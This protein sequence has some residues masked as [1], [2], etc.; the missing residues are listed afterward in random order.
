MEHVTS[1]CGVGHMIKIIE[2]TSDTIIIRDCP[3]RIL[4]MGLCILAIAAVVFTGLADSYV[5]N[6]GRVNEYSTILVLLFSLTGLAIGSCII[7]DHH[8]TYT[9]FTRDQNTATIQKVG[10]LKIET[11]SYRLDEIDDIIILKT[12]NSE[13]DCFYKAALKLKDNRKIPISSACWMKNQD[14]IDGSDALREFLNTKTWQF[15]HSRIYELMQ[16]SCKPI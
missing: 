3:G 13:D 16:V 8:L 14:L 15:S 12:Q 7:F 1:V 11:M 5:K 9:K 2:H 6:E 10:I 4:L